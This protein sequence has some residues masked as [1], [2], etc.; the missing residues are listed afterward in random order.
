M[1]LYLDDDSVEALLVRLLRADGHEVYV[2]VFHA[3][4][5]FSK[6]LRCVT[7]K[8]DRLFAANGSNFAYRLD[9]AN[10]VVGVHH[11]Y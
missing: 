7:V 2:I 1:R 8:H 5:N 6:G 10:L 4:W 3:D 11:A 9:H